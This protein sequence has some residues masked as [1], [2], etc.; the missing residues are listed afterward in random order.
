M[1]KFDYLE[2]LPFLSNSGEVV[3]RL[4]ITIEKIEKTVIFN[5]IL[6][7]IYDEIRK[8][9]MSEVKIY[10]LFNSSYEVTKFYI[11]ILLLKGIDNVAIKRIWIKHFIKKINFNM[12]KLLKECKTVQ[13]RTDVFIDIFRLLESNQHYRLKRITIDD[14]V[15][16]GMH[17]MTYLDVIESL[18][19][20]TTVLHQGHVIIPTNATEFLIG[21]IEKFAEKKINMLYERADYDVTITK[22]INLIISK[23][24]EEILKTQTVSINVKRHFVDKEILLE[25]ERVKD[26]EHA[27]QIILDIEKLEK[28]KNIEGINI[29]TFPP[30]VNVILNKL[31]IKKEKLTHSENIFLCTYLEK[32]HFDIEQVIKIFSKAVNYDNRTTKYQVTF[33]YK[34]GMM[35]QNC[36]N[37][38]TEGICKKELDKTKQ[39]GK[40]K[41]PLSY[42]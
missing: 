39:C 21:F 35:P 29:Q 5:D 40:I 1:N 13:E 34:K 9:I 22:K 2:Y 26:V 42:R 10:P 41:N 19:D 6:E 11:T 8:L 38:V 28:E 32:K 16:F 27:N 17:M 23:L 30:C 3:R 15:A 18:F 25:Q 12:K 24:K 14:D 7:E 4:D 37:L 36:S 31:L 33:L 20:D